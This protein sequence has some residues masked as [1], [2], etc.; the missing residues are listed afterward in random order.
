MMRN[1][2]PW[3]V[4]ASHEELFV[5]SYERLLTWA[6]HLTE[7][8]RELAEDLL[9]DAF[10]QFTLTR[11]DPETI[12]DLDNYLY[13]ILRHLH[14]SQLRRTS[15]S[16]LQQ[17]AIVEYDS[18]QAGL[19]TIDP[20]E[21]IQAQD[22]LRRVCH[23]VCARKETSRAG[24]ILMLRFFHGYYPGEIAQITRSSRPAVEERLRQNPR[25]SI[26]AGRRAC[27]HLLSR[28]RRRRAAG[29]PAWRLG[30]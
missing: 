9:H 21:Q 17:L 29:V 3:K 14:L 2:N 7:S 20:S 6:L 27:Q 1:L 8:N 22:E 19:R 23:Y 13:G 10:I 11:P 12:K 16:R 30:V 18:A 15:R 4:S 26:A 24:S 5:A 25:F 28:D